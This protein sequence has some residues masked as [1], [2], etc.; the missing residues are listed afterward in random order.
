MS[1]TILDS[2]FPTGPVRKRGLLV[3]RDT[4]VDRAVTLL[5][6][7]ATHLLMCG[8]RGIGK[9]S[10]ARVAEVILREG[11]PLARVDYKQC[12]SRTTYVSLL[13]DVLKHLGVIRYRALV[14]PAEVADRLASAS[15]FLLIDEFDRLAQEDRRLVAELMKALSDC[16]SRFAICAVGVAA[17]ALDLFDEHPS[18]AR[19]LTELPVKILAKND[20][21]TIATNGFQALGLAVREDLL[22]DIAR[23]SRG[24]P[25]H[26]VL[27]CRY[28]AEYA[29]NSST[30]K[31]EPRELRAALGN[32]LREKGAAAREAFLRATSGSAGDKARLVLRAAASLTSDEFTEDELAETARFYGVSRE[33]VKVTSIDC[34]ARTPN[35]IFD[36][37]RANTYRFRDPRMPWIILITEYLDQGLPSA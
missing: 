33:Q 24:F 5:S 2:V 23:L 25:A 29:M 26:V 9:T 31:I 16:G 36:V 37:I 18:V 17:T 1:T 30:K 20:I 3:G 22:L 28:T 14:S 34:T 11:D 27:L 7:S 10:I 13:E 6:A 35:Q 12:G 8:L 32:L 19:C 4:E 21:Q 15:G